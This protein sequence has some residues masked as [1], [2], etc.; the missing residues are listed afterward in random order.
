MND[1]MNKK[2]LFFNWDRNPFD[3]N[4]M[5]I[6]VQVNRMKRNRKNLKENIG[7]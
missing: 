1:P 3:K 5:Q 7:S 4:Y 6:E 2:I